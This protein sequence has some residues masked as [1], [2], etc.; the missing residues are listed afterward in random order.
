[1]SSNISMWVVIAVYSHDGGKTEVG[2]LHM[3]EEL[4][5]CIHRFPLT[6]VTGEK[7]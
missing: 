7:I 6:R 1:M 2:I 4:K 3:R 5:K